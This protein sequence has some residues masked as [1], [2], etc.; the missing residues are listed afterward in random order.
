MAAAL[1]LV[2]GSFTAAN[3]AH[4]TSPAPVAQH[5]SS[6]STVRSAALL[7]ADGRPVGRTYAYDG[8]PSW[9]F[10]DVNASGLRGTYTCELHLA[11]GATVSAGVV[12]VYHGTGD[13]AHTV[14]V[15]ASGIRQA[16]LQT[17]TGVA[18]ASATF[19]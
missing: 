18:V 12:V 8:N 9:V 4:S 19:S 3:L 13:W 6:A 15:Q 1:A 16:T 17:S 14:K 11:D 7:T 5:A 10:M 2:A